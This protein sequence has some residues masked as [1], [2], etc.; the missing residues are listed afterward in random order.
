VGPCHYA[1]VHPQVADGECPL[2]WRVAANMLNKKSRTADKGWSYRLEFGRCANKSSQSKL[3]MLQN[4]VQGIRR[5][6][7]G[8]MDWIDL[9]LDRNSL[10]HL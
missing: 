3:E 7:M 9:A 8:S 4:I 10:G 2:I 1:M 5:G 6:G